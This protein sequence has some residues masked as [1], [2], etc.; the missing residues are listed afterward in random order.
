MS[1]QRQEKLLKQIEREEN[2]L[3]KMVGSGQ[4]FL[5]FVFFFFGYWSLFCVCMSFCF[6]FDLVGHRFLWLIEIFHL[7]RF[8]H[9]LGGFK[10][11]LN[12]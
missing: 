9:R 3:A 10:F 4:Y 1:L 8:G 6:R 11:I 12:C 7:A 5:F 2:D